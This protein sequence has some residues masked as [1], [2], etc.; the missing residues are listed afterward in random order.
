MDVTLIILIKCIKVF[1]SLSLIC[2][3]TL[4]L[5][6]SEVSQHKHFQ[7]SW[8]SHTIILKGSVVCRC[9]TCSP[10]SVLI[11][12][13]SAPLLNLRNQMQKVRTIKAHQSKCHH[14]YF[15]VDVMVISGGIYKRCHERLYT[16]AVFNFWQHISQVNHLSVFV[17]ELN[18]TNLK[19]SRFSE[20]IYIRI[21]S[22]VL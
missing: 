6:C 14:V 19:S 10:S 21:V 12:M 11:Y 13:S 22:F 17:L 9:C 4:T 20:H 1:L 16:A 2:I 3:R 18:N 8:I 7:P 5:H 15:T